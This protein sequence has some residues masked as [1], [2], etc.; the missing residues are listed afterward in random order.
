MSAA[1]CVWEMGEE[2]TRSL[3][4]MEHVLLAE[5]VYHH[6]PQWNEA[7]AHLQKHLV[8]AYTPELCQER[9]QQLLTQHASEIQPPQA[10]GLYSHL[11]TVRASELTRAIRDDQ[12]AI[13]QLLKEVKQVQKGQW[14][15]RL[16]KMYPDVYKRLRIEYPPDEQEDTSVVLQ[17][18]PRVR[19]P[20]PSDMNELHT[21][22]KRAM[23]S[24]ID[25]LLTH[26]H[27]PEYS[28]PVRKS[29]AADYYLI[30]KQ[31]MDFMQI[32]RAVA[33]DELVTTLQVQEA[34]YHTMANAVVYNLK[35]SETYKNTLEIF[36]DVQEAMQEFKSV[37][38]EQ[39]IEEDSSEEEEKV[40]RRRK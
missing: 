3:P 26:K 35:G 27:A 21:R 2:V 23:L 32:K 11:Y 12:A 7:A 22:W 25:L 1:M 29:E 18:S 13:Q 15:T 36:A 4:K 31:P 9:Y 38:K 17:E 16:P 28:K 14:D 20:R 10:Y 33:N 24:R 40:R 6:G 37:M 30:V 19:V 39:G 5:F 8:E 34:F